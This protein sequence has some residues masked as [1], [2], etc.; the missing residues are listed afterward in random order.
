MKQDETKIPFAYCIELNEVIDIDTAIIRS[1]ERNYCTFNFLCA[2]EK[3]R[4]IGVKITATNYYKKASERIQAAHF[5]LNN[6]NTNPLHRKKTY[7]KQIRIKVTKYNLMILLN[8][9]QEYITKT[10][11]SNPIILWLLLMMMI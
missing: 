8:I 3:C 11:L 1:A 5:K 7:L 2:Y 6:K 4:Q 9:H 10:I